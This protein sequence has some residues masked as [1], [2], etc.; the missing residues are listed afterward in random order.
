MHRYFLSAF[1][2]LVLAGVAALPAQAMDGF[3]VED[4][5][6]QGL[7]RVSAGTVFNQLPV[8]VG[9]VLNSVG[10]RE[11]IRSLFRSGFFNDI[12]MARDGG[13]LV[14][15]L[16]ERP[17]IE[18][19]EIEGNKAI[20][21]DA[22]LDG[23][24]Q[25]GL[26]EGEIF[27]QAT[28]ERVG[29]ELERQYVA[30]G[31]YGAAIDT[32][33]E[34]LPRNRVAI[35]IDIEEGKT[36]GIR[37][38]NV[39]GAT[40]F[41]EA[42]LLEVLELKHP[43]L[44]SFYKND[45]KYSREK[46]SGDL[47]KLEA[48]YKDR[49]Y[50]EFAITSTQVSITPKRDQVYITLNVEEG[51]KFTVNEVNL[52]GELN[53]VRKEDLERL[54]IVS[55]G[56]V[57]SQAR[58][59]ATEER[60]TNALGN[61]G[62]TFASATGVP[63]VQDDGTVDVEF[64]VDAGKRAYVRRISFSGNKVTRDEVMR[65]E[66]RQMEGGWAST[67]QIE[68]SKV[69][70]ER[71]GYFKG[72]NV[73]TPEVA[74]TDDQVDVEFVVEEQ[75]SGSISATLGYA[76]GWGL[77]LGANYSENNVL[78]T[79]N[80]LTIGASYSQYQK[81]LNFNYYNPYYTLDGISRGFNMFVRN[82][83]YD[84][85]NIAS[86]ST[87]AIG[88]GITF[89]FPIGETQR[90]NFGAIIEYTDITEGAFP[91]REISEYLD[92]NGSKSLN[93]KLNLGWRS[94]TLNRGVFPTRGRAQNLSMEVA[95]PG[96]DLTFYKIVYDGQMYLPITRSW[97]LRLRTEVGYGDGYGSTDL[98]PFF[99][100]FYAG[101]FG[102]IRGF[103]NSTLGPRTTPPTEDADGNPIPPGFFRP[104][105]DP[106]GGNLLVEAGAEI[107]FPMP[108]IKDGR[109]FRPVVFVDAGNVFQTQCFDFSVNCFDFDVDEFRYSVGA[110]LTWLAGLGPMT[111]SYAFV[112]N[113]S[114]VDRV[115]QFQFEL[116]RTF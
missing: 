88:G 16:V 57:F 79:G 19:I 15:T 40:V 13:V 41:D 14:V 12:R 45:D 86:F 99:E 87:D 1:L 8:S 20:P 4:I 67:S 48:F 71:L 55:P 27:K 28:L 115:E 51:E 24:G 53:D 35:S 18:S 101:G 68:L 21:T 106:Y 59:T 92:V 9:D 62:Y 61:S 114:P 49:G 60:L 77:T 56:Q 7:Q 108:F 50:V 75:P 46:L 80:S 100:H 6:L 103:R 91:A 5:R 116:G 66:M 84:A 98:I 39:V 76:Q 32:N 22:L 97:T 89:G 94:S 70:L 37:H 63:R 38:I 29:L 3:V 81:A 69:R 73:E 105:G 36:S 111:F 52:I 30:Q 26:R 74:G 11:L 102:S 34:E 47:E 110:S 10:V 96:S 64:F 42:E 112:F 17:A 33:V 54:L 95:V 109:Q 2:T 85:R 113:D 90:I 65:R 23:L 82:L 72:V 93:Y 25:Q 107:I 31:R 43:S 44:L 58:V 104:E 78:G 83:D